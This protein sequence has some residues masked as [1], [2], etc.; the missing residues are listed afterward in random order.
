MKI[1]EI[2]K[3]ELLYEKA[4]ELRYFMFFKEHN[5]SKNILND[6]KEEKSTHIA[7][8]QDDELIAYGRLTALNSEEFQISQNCC[9]PQLSRSGL[10]SKTIARTRAIRQK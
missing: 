5:L 3:D 9:A 2:Q 8:S 7:I 10:R 6:E 4:L 1:G